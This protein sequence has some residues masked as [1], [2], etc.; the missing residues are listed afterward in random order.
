L[1]EHWKNTRFR[2]KELKILVAM[3]MLNETISFEEK[4][5]KKKRQR[6]N[7]IWGAAEN[8]KESVNEVKKRK[9]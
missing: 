1:F 8:G 2:N 7:K 3:K 9:N 5:L 6:K 4:N